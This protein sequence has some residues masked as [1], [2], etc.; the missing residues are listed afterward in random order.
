VLVQ[1]LT[2]GELSS[3]LKPVTKASYHMSDSQTIPRG[4]LGAGWRASI[5]WDLTQLAADPGAP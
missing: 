2:K 1:V 3:E 5:P 4:K